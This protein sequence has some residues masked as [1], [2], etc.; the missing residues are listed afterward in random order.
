MT[1]QM[2]PAAA[3]RMGAAVIDVSA[4]MS[5]HYGVVE[6]ALDLLER[7][8]SPKSAQQVLEGLKRMMDRTYPRRLELQRAW[9]QYREAGE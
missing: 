4:A 3:R 6:T 1:E 8:E 5:A 7:G 9:E 2:D